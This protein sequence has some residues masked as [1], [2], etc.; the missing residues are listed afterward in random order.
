MTAGQGF[1]FGDATELTTSNPIEVTHQTTGS[2]M[3]SSSSRGVGFYFQY[4]VL[5]IGVVGTA[6]NG[7]IM[8]ALIASRQHTKH[9]LIF[10]QNML[11]FVSCVFLVASYSFRICNIRLDGTLG[12]WLCI[13]LW[14]EGLSWGPYIGSLMNLAAITVE[15][16]LLVVHFAWAK[17][18]LH[19]SM[20][21]SAAAFTWIGG[22]IVV[23]AVT[24]PT[25]DVVN[26]VCYLLHCLID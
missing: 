2:S 10:N 6:A 3:T 15:R 9:V 18:N 19:K 13:T 7:L 25:S 23:S 1:T 5:V 26:G 11:D 4:T 24:I 21:Y 12:Y 17:K 16:Y 22:V 20:I 8:Y 14:G